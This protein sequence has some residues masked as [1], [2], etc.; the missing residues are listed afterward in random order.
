L[1]GILETVLYCREDTR[2]KMLR[3]YDDVLG[4]AECRISRGGYRLGSGML[5]VF[6]SDK[7]SSQ[8]SP[9]PHGTMG[10]GH[11]CFVSPPGDYGRWQQWLRGAG[12]EIIEEIDWD[13]PFHGRSFYF[14]DPAGN[15]LEIADRDIWPPASRRESLA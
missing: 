1:S 9:P 11:T 14:H 12:V 5:L 7:S 6:N 3:F 2:E 8:S 4:L 13:T 15:V 10:R